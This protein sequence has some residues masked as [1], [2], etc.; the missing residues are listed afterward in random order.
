MGSVKAYESETASMIISSI[1]F[2][3]GVGKTTVAQN[4]AISFKQMGYKVCLVDADDTKASTHWTDKRDELGIQPTIPCA[5]LT[6]PKSFSKQ[7]RAQY[8]NYDIIIV[9]CPPALSAIAVKAMYLS[10]LLIIPVSA[11]GGSD[12]WVTERL[13]EEFKKIRELKEESG[14]AV[15][16]AQ[17]LLNLV[18]SN[19][20]L[21][22]LTAELAVEL[23]QQHGIGMFATQL[24]S[25][26]AYG[27]ANATG[28]GVLELTD[29]KAAAE[30]EQ[31]TQ[32]VLAL[33]TASAE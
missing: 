27:E 28:R 21:H 29:Q 19:V 30:I 13:L 4:L 15:V 20:S 26:V 10:E 8:E 14:D 12:I 16:Q 24:H 2:K 22:G 9:D 3:G 1:N 7:I 17:L 33:A 6:N 5:L 25:R 23:A 11:T 31:L 32:E 18:R